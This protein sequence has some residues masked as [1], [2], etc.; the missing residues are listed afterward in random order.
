MKKLGRAVF[1]AFVAVF[2]LA[3][4]GP[5]WAGSLRLYYSTYLGGS[6]DDRGRGIAVDPSGSAY[7]TGYTWSTDF[8]TAQA[9]QG[10]H[11]GGTCNAFV[12]KLDPSGAALVYPIVA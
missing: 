1:G 12:S 7:V 10:T 8:P 5:V 11:G 4:A 2:I 3:S 9:F 6:D